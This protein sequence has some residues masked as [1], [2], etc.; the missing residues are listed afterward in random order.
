LQ[1]QFLRAFCRPEVLAARLA[2]LERDT[3]ENPSE[4]ELRSTA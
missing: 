1:R 4:V 2:S 3:G